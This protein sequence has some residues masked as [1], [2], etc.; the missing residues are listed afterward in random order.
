[1]GRIGAFL[2]KLLGQLV[3]VD[4][5]VIEKNLLIAVDG[6]HQALLGDLLNG[7]RFGHGDIDAGLQDRR[8]NHEDD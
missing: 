3:D 8:G 1:M 4:R 2:A 5:L 7:A 6:Q